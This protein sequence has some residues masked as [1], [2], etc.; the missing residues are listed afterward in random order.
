MNNHIHVVQVC[1][2]GKNSPVVE[3]HLLTNFL[4]HQKMTENFSSIISSNYEP[5]CVA[6]NDNGLH[7]HIFGETI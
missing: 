5:H 6:L 2:A 1:G 3:L 7:T 4:L